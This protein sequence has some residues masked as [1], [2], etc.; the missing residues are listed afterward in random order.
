MPP[1]SLYLRLKL[2]LTEIDVPGGTHSTRGTKVKPCPELME[3]RGSGL[4]PPV[5]SITC[6]FLYKGNVEKRTWQ[7]LPVLL[8]NYFFLL[9]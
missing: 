8:R 5:E 2:V 3:G 1:H 9:G 7:M 4:R 6:L